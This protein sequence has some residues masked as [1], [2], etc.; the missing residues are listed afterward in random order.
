MGQN[1]H[2][3]SKWVG[4]KLHASAL[5]FQDKVLG[6]VKVVALQCC[7]NLVYVGGRLQRRIEVDQGDK[8]RAG[9]I[10]VSGLQIVQ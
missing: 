4:L 2:W 7:A 6:R 3:L 1:A 10:Q 8:C 9:S 5:Q